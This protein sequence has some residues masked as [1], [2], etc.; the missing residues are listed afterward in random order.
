VT[1]LPRSSRDGRQA[2]ERR[3]AD[4]LA[5]FHSE[6]CIVESLMA[7]TVTGRAAIAGVYQ[8]WFKAFP[9]V[10]MTADDLIIDGNRAVL[11]N[12]VT[13]T[14]TG[15]FMG[16]SGHRPTVQAVVDSSVCLERR[17]HPA[18]AAYL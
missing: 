11:V 17:R 1:K 2:V 15:G 10:I 13:G 18:R 9:D 12:S 3:D 5:A 16:P 4:A 6:D 8:A 7:G 14:D